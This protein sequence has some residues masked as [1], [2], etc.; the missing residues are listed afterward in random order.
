MTTPTIAP[1]NYFSSG[2]NVLR[3]YGGVSS[4][5][6]HHSTR[7]MFD[8]GDGCAGT[9]GQAI[10]AVE[11][12]FI[13]H[14]HFDHI[15]GLRSFVL[16]RDKWKGDNKKKLNIYT[17]DVAAV[18]RELGQFHF[19][20]VAIHE[21]ADGDEIFL[22]GGTFVHVMKSYHTA[23]SVVYSVMRH[24][25][26]LNDAGYAV[27]SE[28]NYNELRTHPELYYVETRKP[29]F[30]YLLDTP[31]LRKEWRPLLDGADFIISDCTFLE[32][33]DKEAQS[34]A[35]LDDNL[36]MADEIECKLF[37]F[38]HISHRYDIRKYEKHLRPG[39]VF[40]P[41]HQPVHIV[42]NL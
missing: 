32:S 39:C 21:V 33:G 27:V 12:I 28:K 30:A 29:I 2:V 6:F 14:H 41:Y 15:G 22:V 1:Y 25:R 20:F 34:H 40:A 42:H 38:G 17:A 24:T 31:V 8:C 4:F 23:N 3:T 18:R 16:A 11:N 7:T 9:L 35:T 19:D 13:T 10:F 26:R 37:V 36:A 5:F